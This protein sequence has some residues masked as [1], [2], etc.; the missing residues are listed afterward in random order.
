MLSVSFYP[1]RRRSFETVAVS[2]LSL[3]DTRFGAFE[4]GLFVADHR[5]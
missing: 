2:T 3:S 1:T 5:L 4:I